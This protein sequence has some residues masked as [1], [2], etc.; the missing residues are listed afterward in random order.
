MD[1]IPFLNYCTGDDCFWCQIA[2]EIV[3]RASKVY[4]RMLDEMLAHTDIPP[5]LAGPNA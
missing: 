2:P 3:E 5:V 1:D 4:A